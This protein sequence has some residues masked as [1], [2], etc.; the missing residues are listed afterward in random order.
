MRI[1]QRFKQEFSN[2]ILGNSYIDLNQ[3]LREISMT[4][5]LVNISLRIKP[6][7][8]QKNNNQNLANLLVRI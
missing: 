6:R 2:I 1:E 5:V 8:N 4:T 7:F 3:E